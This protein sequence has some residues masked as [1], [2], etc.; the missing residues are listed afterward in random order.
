MRF[1]L[2]IPILQFIGLACIPEGK[3]GDAAQ[4]S[5][6]FDST[7]IR[8]GDP[9]DTAQTPFEGE[10]IQTVT[11]VDQS[12][13][14]T[15]VLSGKS[16]YPLNEDLR[17]AEFHAYAFATPDKLPHPQW[18]LQEV[19]DS[20]YCDCAVELAEGSIPIRD[21]D[22]DGV[23]EVFL[24]YF[25]NDLC[26]VSPMFTRLTVASGKNTYSLEGYTRRFQAPD[27]PEVKTISP[28]PTFASAPPAIQ[29]AAYLFWEDYLEKEQA[30]FEVVQKELEENQD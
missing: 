27:L 10:L 4:T 24:M 7:T 12:G 29:Q 9:I 2:L 19:V 13:K 14:N 3:T 22:Q 1:I 8:E 26:D 23:A 18:L 11:W 6:V 17:R 15:L 16:A 21:V 28:G 5:V 20:C 30:A 25:L